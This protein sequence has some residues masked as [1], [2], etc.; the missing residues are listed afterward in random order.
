MQPTG[1]SSQIRD[2][3][4]TLAAWIFSHWITRGVLSKHFNRNCKSFCVWS[5]SCFSCLCP[6]QSFFFFFF[7]IKR[8]C[9]ARLSKGEEARTE[10]HWRM[11]VKDSRS[12]TTKQ[13][14]I[15]LCLHL[16]KGKINLMERV[17]KHFFSHHGPT[18]FISSC[19][20]SRCDAPSWSRRMKDSQWVIDVTLHPLPPRLTFTL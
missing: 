20:D 4:P 11:E 5:H 17:I 18:S 10:R 12:Q 1:S 19:S 2:P 13:E 15:C 3:N 8:A 16:P 7:L 9:S 14:Q 6:G